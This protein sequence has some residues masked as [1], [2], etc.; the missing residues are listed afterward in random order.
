MENFYSDIMCLEYCEICK[1]EFHRME[2][3]YNPQY[4]DCDRWQCKAL[5]IFNFGIFTVLALVLIIPLIVF[6]LI[7]IIY[8]IVVG[9]RYAV[10]EQGNEKEVHGRL[11]R[12]KLRKSSMVKYSM[13]RKQPRPKK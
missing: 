1:E 4:D 3:G 5:D 13:A 7:V 11:E 9:N 8:D 12:K 10:Q 6:L 2:L